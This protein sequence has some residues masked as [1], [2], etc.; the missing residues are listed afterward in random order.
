MATCFNLTR[1]PP[2][3]CSLVAFI[4]VMLALFAGHD[5]RFLEGYDILLVN[6][7]GLGNDMVN[8]A[9]SRGITPTPLRNFRDI[10]CQSFGNEW[11]ESSCTTASPVVV[12]TDDKAGSKINEKGNDMVGKLAE[13]PHIHEF[14]TMHALAVCEGDFKEDGSRNVTACHALFSD[15]TNSIPSLL[16]T[17]L[18]LNLS[19]V[20]KNTTLDSIGVK[21]T[22]RSALDSLNVLLKAVTVIFSIGV[23]FTG[24]SFLISAAGLFFEK[25]NTNQSVPLIVWTSLIIVSSALFFLI[26]GALTATAGAKTVEGKVNSLDGNPGVSATLGLKWVTLAWIGVLLMVLVLGYWVFQVIQFMRKTRGRPDPEGGP[27]MEDNGVPLRKV[28]RGFHISGPRS[29]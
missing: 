16:N 6:T 7:S 26:L 25:G 3:L 28:Q 22:L 12:S 27:N 17:S 21:G 9:V 2:V 23:A 19:P 14:Y 15:D 18:H 8:M 20:D 5:P 29:H 10:A 11:L 13:K 4:L 1:L 24:I